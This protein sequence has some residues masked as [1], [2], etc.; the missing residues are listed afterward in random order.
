MQKKLSAYSTPVYYSHSLLSPPFFHTPFSCRD[1]KRRIWADVEMAGLQTDIFAGGGGGGVESLW[2][3]KLKCATQT[4]CEA[5]LF[6]GGLG[7][8]RQEMFFFC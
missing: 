4:A 3:S 6:L 5:H 8:C 2:D 7:V 1:V